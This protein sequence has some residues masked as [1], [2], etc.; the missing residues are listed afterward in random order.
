MG[1]GALILPGVSIGDHSVIG[2]HS[3]VSKNIPARCVAAGSPAKA[4]KTFECNDDWIRNEYIL[5]MFTIQ[6]SCSD[7]NYPG[8]KGK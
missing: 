3:V 1:L 6:D 2:A 7:G 4:V 8:T 5:E